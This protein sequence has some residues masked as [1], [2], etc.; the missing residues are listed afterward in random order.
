ML[1]PRKI[2]ITTSNLTMKIVKA[3]PG[4]V[5]KKTGRVRAVIFYIYI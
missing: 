4:C 2:M 1:V 3:G 5:R